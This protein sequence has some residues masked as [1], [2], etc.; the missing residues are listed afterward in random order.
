M[1]N[2]G[3]RLPVDATAKSKVKSARPHNIPNYA[4][5]IVTTNE[6]VDG[7]SKI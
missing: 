6:V 3:A 7:I 5:A 2:L 4:S 1:D